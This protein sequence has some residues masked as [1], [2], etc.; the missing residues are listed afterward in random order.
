LFEALPA[1]ATGEVKMI[2]HAAAVFC[3]VDFHQRSKTSMLL[4]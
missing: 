4:D 3:F 2:R 1:L